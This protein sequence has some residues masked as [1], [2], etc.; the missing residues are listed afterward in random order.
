MR[1]DEANFIGYLACVSSENE[2]FRYS[3]YL[4]GW[5]YAG[6]DPGA[7]RHEALHRTDEPALRRSKAGPG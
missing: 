3:G 7:G 5:V 6:N 4:T 1:E 2:A